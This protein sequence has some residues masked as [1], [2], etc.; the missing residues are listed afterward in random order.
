MP[1][2]TGIMKIGDVG[3]D[4]YWPEVLSAGLATVSNVPTAVLQTSQKRWD[5][6]PHPKRHQ[7]AKVEMLVTT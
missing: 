2:T 1:R 4:G 5:A 3:S 6:R 7:R